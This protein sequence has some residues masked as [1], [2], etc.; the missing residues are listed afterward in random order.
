MDF[1]ESGYAQDYLQ[2]I[3]KMDVTFTTFFLERPDVAELVSGA[4][5]CSLVHVPRHPTLSVAHDVCG[6][7][8]SVVLMSC[9]T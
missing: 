5:W 1:H 2:R 8:I 7:F 3:N 6:L 4:E 9:T